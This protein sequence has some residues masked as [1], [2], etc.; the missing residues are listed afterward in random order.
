MS[1]KLAVASGI[2]Y[3]TY[4]A[5]LFLGECSRSLV[6]HTATECS[7]YIQSIYIYIY[8]I[9]SASHMRPGLHFQ[10]VWR[11]PCRCIYIYIDVHIFASICKNMHILLMAQRY[12]EC[13]IYN[14]YACKHWNAAYVGAEAMQ[15]T[16]LCCN[17]PGLANANQVDGLTYRLGDPSE[18]SVHM[19]PVKFMSINLGQGIV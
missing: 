13:C 17:L 16:V 4:K 5:H 18:F 19:V 9:G 6:S 7:F 15:V 3:R 8:I 2:L 12:R 11:K 14:V 10:N 1:R